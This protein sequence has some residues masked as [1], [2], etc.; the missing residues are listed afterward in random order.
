MVLVFR[1]KNDAPTFF[2]F[3]GDISVTFLAV[4]REQMKGSVMDAMADAVDEADVVL[5]CVS[6]AYKESGAQRLL[7][8]TGRSYSE[9]ARLCFVFSELPPRSK[10]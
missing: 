6:L 5:F 2:A 8:Q 1:E 3:P 9:S 4:C 10:L 7:A